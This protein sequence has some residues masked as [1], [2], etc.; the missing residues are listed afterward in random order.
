MATWFGR[1]VRMVARGFY[2]DVSLEE[3]QSKPNGSG[4]CGIVVV[5]LDALT[6]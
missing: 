1:L 5:V 4:S 3:D 6:R 2:E